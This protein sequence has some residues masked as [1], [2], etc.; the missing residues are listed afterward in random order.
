MRLEQ[1]SDVIT[2][3]KQ[4]AYILFSFAIPK[5]WKASSLE[6]IY[7]IKI[8]KCEQSYAIFNVHPKK[9]YINSQVECKTKLSTAQQTK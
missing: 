6:T 2:K 9:S 5:K 1:Q 3:V 7:A 8:E 4:A